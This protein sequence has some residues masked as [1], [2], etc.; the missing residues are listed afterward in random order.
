MYLKFHLNGMLWCVPSKCLHV[1]IHQPAAN[2]NQR[3]ISILF[4]QTAESSI[5]LEVATSTIHSFTSQ[6]QYFSSA[7]AFF[8]FPS[9]F[10]FLGLLLAS[11]SMFS[12]KVSH[13]RIA[14]LS[15]GRLYLYLCIHFHY[16]QSHPF[17]FCHWSII[18]DASGVDEK[19]IHIESIL[20]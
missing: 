20:E 15:T 6:R 14:V 3:Q 16:T 9:L 19:F 12:H 18:L 4:V 8:F 7:L 5:K 1:Y 13:R 17:D 11:S 2:V 10:L